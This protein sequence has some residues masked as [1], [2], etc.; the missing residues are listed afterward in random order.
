M[1]FWGLQVEPTKLYSQTVDASYKVTMA[2]IDPSAKDG[3]KVVLKVR[4]NN[5]MEFVLCTLVAG[6]EE[7]KVESPVKD[8]AHASETEVVKGDVEMEAKD[9]ES[10]DEESDE[11]AEMTKEEVISLLKQQGHSEKEIEEMLNGEDDDSE[12]EDEDSEGEEMTKEQFV[13]LLK[14]EGKTDEEIEEIL[15]EEEDEDEEFEQIVESLKKEGYSDEQIQEMLEQMADD[16]EVDSDEEI[17][18]NSKRQKKQDEKPN[19]K[20]KVEETP[21]K[22]KKNEKK[23]NETPK[24]AEKKVTETPKKAAEKKV[25][26][27]PKKVAETPKKESNKKTLANGL[28]IEDRKVGDGKKASKNNKVAV[29]YVGKLSNGKVFDSNTKGRPFEFV[30]G[31]GQVIKGWDLGIEGMAIGGERRLVIPAP[32]AYGKQGAGDIPKNATLTFD[33]KLLAIK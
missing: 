14:A 28:V 27:T 2:A 3:E 13:E 18:E 5:D 12:E 16:D 9:E 29:R 22:E 30:L 11:E 23:V 33:V 32:L 20:Q 10:S 24:P 8:S 15:A 19:K 4:V 1:Q 31:K 26:E 17:K 21:K 6:R 25:A 7:P